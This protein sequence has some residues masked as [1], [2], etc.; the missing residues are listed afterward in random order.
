MNSAAS[1]PLKYKPK[2]FIATTGQLMP[3]KSIRPITHALTKFLMGD[4]TPFIFFIEYVS[5]GER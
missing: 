5:S 4:G 1:A 3:H 2:S